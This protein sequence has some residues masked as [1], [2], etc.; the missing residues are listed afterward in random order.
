VTE[1]IGL[2]K[3]V[4]SWNEK[5]LFH[6]FGVRDD[7]SPVRSICVTAEELRVA[8]Q[9]ADKSADEVQQSFFQQI[10]GS[11]PAPKTGAAFEKRMASQTR[12]KVAG[13]TNLVP[14]G[15]VFLIASCLA[16]NEIIEDEDNQGLGDLIV[17]DFREVLARLLDVNDVAISKLLASTWEDLQD[18]LND[19][20]VILFEYGGTTRL[21]KLELPNPGMETHIGYSKKIVF[22]SRRD[23]GKLIEKLKENDVVEVI[24]AVDDVLSVVARSKSTFS[25]TG[26]CF[27]CR[28]LKTSSISPMPKARQVKDLS[29]RQLDQKLMDGTV[30]LL[31][32]ILMK[33]QSPMYYKTQVDWGHSHR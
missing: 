2:P 9:V 31:F 10:R 8:A 29:H 6:Y 16:A 13:S 30:H 3:G 17:R 33:M 11:L 20:P 21:R 26:F 4:Q 28:I 27:I 22:P 7:D 12:V 15:F 18:Y 25:N 5:L 1:Q 14:G 32:L 24:P 19:E 23:Q